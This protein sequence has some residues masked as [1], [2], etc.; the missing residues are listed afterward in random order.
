MQVP[1]ELTFRDVDKSDAIEALVHEKI[2]KLERVCGELT[3]C[4]V[5]IERPH[6]RRQTG[7][8]YRVRLDINVPPGHDI[9]ITEE[10][11]PDQKSDP[12]HGVVREAFETAR[13]RL[14]RLSEKR[15][16]ARKQPPKTPVTALVSELNP[17]EGSGRLRTPDGRDIYFQRNAVLNDD[18]DRLEIGTGV[19]H[20]EKMDEKGPVASTVQIVD[21]PSM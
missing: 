19:R 2:E 3:S 5:A 14:R 21:K 15:Q 17:V 1:L 13:R 7:D 16:D 20:V 9:V 8:Q 6:K 4:R 18:Y 12:L 10:S 11:D